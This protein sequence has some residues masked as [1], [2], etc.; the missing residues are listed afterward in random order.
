M[1]CPSAF[2][3]LWAVEWVYSSAVTECGSSR[4]LHLTRCRLFRCRIFTHTSQPT[5]RNSL[6]ITSPL[7]NTRHNNKSRH[8]PSTSRTG[9]TYGFCSVHTFSTIQDFPSIRSTT[10]DSTVIEASPATERH[11]FI[12][13]PPKP[14]TVQNKETMAPQKKVLLKVCCFSDREVAVGAIADG[15]LL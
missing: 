7:L 13:Y 11:Q 8:F 15:G 4:L 1:I 10:Q 3:S 9:A 2:T 14:T 6:Y 5:N 12:D